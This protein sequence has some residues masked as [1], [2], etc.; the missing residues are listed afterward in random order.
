MKQTYIFLFLLLASVTASAANFYVY[1]ANSS[2]NWDNGSTWNVKLRTD[3]KQINKVIIPVNITIT[4]T[5][6]N[7]TFALGD[8]EIEISGKLLLAKKASLILSANSTINLLMGTIDTDPKKDKSEQIKIGN[9]VK[10]ASVI[11]NQIAGNWV[12]NSNTGTSPN[13]FASPAILPVTFV[14]FT[15]S[16]VDDQVSLSWATTDEIN[17]SHFEIERST[18]GVNFSTVGIVFPA[19]PVSSINMYKFKDRINTKLSVYYRIRQVDVN[20]QDLYSSVKIIN[21]ISNKIETKIYVSSKNTITADLKQAPS[22][23][24]IIRLMNVNGVVVSSQVYNQPTSKITLT[25]DNLLPGSYVVSV[26]DLKGSAGTTKMV[27]L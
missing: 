21:G 8:V 12:S 11:D 18:D 17:N 13:G 25:A 6:K 4:V 9:T 23:P 14:S 1:T 24:V 2:G 26:T 5:A 3:N 7:S 15:A 20:G 16:K 19:E 27:I 22:N 10:F